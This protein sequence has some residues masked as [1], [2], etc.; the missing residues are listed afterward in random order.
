[1]FIDR[2]QMRKTADE[3]VKNNAKVAYGIMVVP[4]IIIILVRIVIS[5]LDIYYLVDVINLLYI[6][7]VPF[8]ISI[9][10]FKVIKSEEI[11][12]K[13]SLSM[14]NKDNLLRYY[15]GAL[16]LNVYAFLWTLLFIIPG[17]I[18]SF[19][20]SMTPFIM[21][22]DPS[23]N[24]NQAITR[25]REMMDGY[26][27]DI[28]FIYFRYYILPVVLMTIGVAAYS[29]SFVALLFGIEVVGAY[30]LSLLVLGIISPIIAIVLFI[31]NCARYYAAT[32]IFYEKLTRENTMKDVF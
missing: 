5:L 19:S 27:K 15:L 30:I 28:F 21:K 3:L 9:T 17:L 2:K 8:L 16:L 1:M 11:S 25:S 24:A 20:Y 13:K 14:E 10:L 18:K 29:V 22:E 23:L 4:F 26:K 7:G 31:R 6:V 12:F 32:A